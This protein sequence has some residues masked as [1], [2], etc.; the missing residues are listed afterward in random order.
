M[1]SASPE[2]P[3]RHQEYCNQQTRQYDH[4]PC[5]AR[6]KD[7]GRVTAQYVGYDTDE[8]GYSAA[9]DVT[10]DTVL[11]QSEPDYDASGNVI[12]TTSYARKHTAGG[13]GAL[14][15]S[16]A[17]VY[18]ASWYDD[19][20]RQEDSANYGTNGGSTFSRPSSAPTRSDTVLVTSTEYNT[21]GQA[22]KTTDPA[23]KESQSTFDDAGRVTKQIDNYT[24]GNPASGGS[25]EDVTVEMAY[26]SDGKL[27]TL[28]AKNP[29][30]GD[31]VTTYVYGTATGGITPEIYR[32]DVLRA[33]IYPDSDDTSSLANGGDGVY[34]RIEYTY[35]IQGN[36]LTRK[37][38]NGTIH[39]Y[40]YDTAARAHDRVTT[41]GSGV[42][43]GVLRVSTTYDI[44]GLREKITSYDNATVG[45]VTV[46]NEVVY[47]YNDLGM[48]VKEYRASPPRMILPG[49]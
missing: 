46:V 30:T 14:T 35:N 39:T 36:R 40:E 12:Q 43:G 18:S 34:D 11:Q 47:E 3:P 8:T 21:A 37:D 32:N 44:R 41:L 27:T 5:R 24:D 13:T 20:D 45:S 2:E 49:G 9:A 26:N 22:Y 10:G 29:T 19:A 48:P 33:E 31:Q 25:D 42:D 28:T 4:K 6:R 38:Q 7:I 1:R 17:R 15:T 23:G 16:T